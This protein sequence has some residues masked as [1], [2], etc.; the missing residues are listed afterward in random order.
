[1]QVYAD[2]IG[3]DIAVAG[4]E[5][6]SVLGAAMLDV[7]VAGKQDGGYDSLLEAVAGMAPTLAR[8]YHASPEHPTSYNAIYAQYLRLYDYLGRGESND[9]MK[10]LRRLRKQ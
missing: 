3:R 5:K 9:A 7:M 2:I 1:M 4:T 10:I 8:V 6:A